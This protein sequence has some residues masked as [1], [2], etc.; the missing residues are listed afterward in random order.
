MI[1]RIVT[2]RSTVDKCTRNLK[3][4][5]VSSK[6]VLSTF[7]DNE[8]FRSPRSFGRRRMFA[9]NMFMTANLSFNVL[10]CHELHFRREMNPRVPKWFW[11]RSYVPNLSRHEVTFHPITAFHKT[12]LTQLYNSS[13][14]FKHKIALSQNFWQS[15]IHSKS[16]VF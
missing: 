2:N 13:Q 16:R 14:S 1:T 15:S 10:V 9:T 12:F 11:L 8:D 7:D 6:Q 5:F 3:Q 4:Y